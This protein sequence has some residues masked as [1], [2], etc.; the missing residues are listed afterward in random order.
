[1][2]AKDI[3]VSALR[4]R[5]IVTICLNCASPLHIS[6]N[7][8]SYFIETQENRQ[9]DFL[10]CLYITTFWPFRGKECRRT[11]RAYSLL[12]PCPRKFMNLAGNCGFTLSRSQKLFRSAMAEVLLRAWVYLSAISQPSLQV[13]PSGVWTAH[14][15]VSLLGMPRSTNLLNV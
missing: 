3:F 10:T 7:Q 12:F 5:R 2:V 15:T 11:S 1:V 8:S 4:S 13:L 14:W 6:I 9:P